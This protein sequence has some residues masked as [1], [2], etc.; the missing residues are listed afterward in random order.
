VSARFLQVQ[1]VL[2]VQ[3]VAASVDWYTG[4]LGFTLAFHAPEHPAYAVLT[5]DDVELHLQWHDPTEWGNGDRPMLRFLVADVDAVHAEFA[6]K[7]V[8]HDRTALRDTPWGTREL[9]FYDPD[10]NGLTFYRPR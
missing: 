5:R 9:A 8:F 6:P 2:G 7:G 1:P 3:D 4:R 10:R